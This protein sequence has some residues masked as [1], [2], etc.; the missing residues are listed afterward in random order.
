M[1]NLKID[2]DPDFSFA[3]FTVG[4]GVFGTIYKEGII[5]FEILCED[6]MSFELSIGEIQELAAAAKLV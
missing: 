2:T 6:E 1:S 5:L 4:N 3:S